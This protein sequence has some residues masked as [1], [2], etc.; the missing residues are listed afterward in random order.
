MKNLN[1]LH[2]LRIHSNEP[3]EIELIIA[4]YKPGIEDL[5]EQMNQYTQHV[6]RE[7]PGVRYDVRVEKFHNSKKFIGRNQELASNPIGI[8]FWGEVKKEGAS[9]K[10]N[11]NNTT[12]KYLMGFYFGNEIKD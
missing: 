2:E 3:S 8:Y 9:F 11:G 12:L 1:E 4:G 5:V 6:M 7:A 10:F